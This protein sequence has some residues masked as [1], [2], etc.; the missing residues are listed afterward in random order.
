M[1]Y[2]IT[3][4][5]GYDGRI[6]DPNVEE[7]RGIVFHAG[8]EKTRDR[9]IELGAVIEVPGKRA[10]APPPPPPPPAPPPS[11]PAPP[12]PANDKPLAELPLAELKAIA[13]AEKVPGYGIIR[14]P[15]KLAAA[16]EAHRAPK[17]AD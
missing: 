14:D 7:D 1:R 15:A 9:L 6:R 16:V 13:K 12:P 5:V 8:D 2:E 3:R 17:A 10:P 4:K 11:P